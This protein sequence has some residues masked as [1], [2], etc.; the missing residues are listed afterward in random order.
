MELVIVKLSG[1]LTDDET[2]IGKVA[3]YINKVNRD[4]I[5]VIIVHGGGKQINKLSDT[6]GIPNNQVDG[7]RVTTPETLDVL[8]YT[9]GGS[10]NRNL[11]SILRKYGIS[12]V[13]ITG[14]DGFLSTSVRRPPL[15]IRGNDIDF[16]LVGEIEGFDTTLVEVLLENGF[17]PVIGCLTWAAADGVLNI[18]A[19]TFSTKLAVACN[20]K[21]LSMLMEPEAVLNAG[22]QPIQ[23]IN[24]SEFDLGQKSGWI[25]DG[26][27]PKLKT[28]FDALNA[29]VRNVRLTNPDGLLN[30]SG[31]KLYN[32][33]NYG[34]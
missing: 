32:T 6:L 18:N 3:E 12:G 27:I 24:V 1:A 14:V 26:M 8:M 9:V 21:E 16:Q 7:R 30:E 17:T 25:K 28:G 19:D 23:K 11:V 13:G 15:N 33:I 34:V 31:T 20:C 29:G 5:R 2:Q 22:G 10:V 4:G